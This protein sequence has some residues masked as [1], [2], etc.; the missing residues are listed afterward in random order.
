MLKGVSS[1]INNRILNEESQ[2]D[3]LLAISE[4]EH[5]GFLDE[6]VEGVQN[7]NENGDELSMLDQDNYLLGEDTE[8]GDPDLTTSFQDETDADD[9]CEYDGDSDINADTALDDEVDYDDNFE[10]DYVSDTLPNS[11]LD[12]EE[13]YSDNQTKPVDLDAYIDESEEFD[14]N[15][16][17]YLSEAGIDGTIPDAEE[18]DDIV[19][20][21]DL[22]DD[23]IDADINWVDDD[24]LDETDYMDECGDSEYLDEAD[25]DAILEEACDD[26]L[27]EAGDEEFGTEDIADEEGDED[28]LDEDY[29]TEEED[30][31]TEDIAD[32]EGDEFAD[33]LEE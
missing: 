24:D 2:E 19:V 22:E 26:F 25:A 31:D 21:A 32:E 18:V 15:D 20:D 12:K 1:T 7:L 8:Y 9:D 5:I 23:E 27:S 28:F 14:M 3:F 4:D 17:D 16:Y 11:L 30:L 13:T 29:F 33:E 6:D 10:T